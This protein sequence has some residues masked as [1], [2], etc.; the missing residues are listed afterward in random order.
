MCP[1]EWSRKSHLRRHLNLRHKLSGEKAEKELNKILGLEEDNEKDNVE[2]QIGNEAAAGE[3][4]EEDDLL[5]EPNFEKIEEQEK[6]INEAEESG[7]EDSSRN[8]GK[9]IPDEEIRDKADES[10]K[11][12]PN[13]NFGEQVPE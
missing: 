4:V 11:E 1:A 6:I 3:A 10:V 7:E 9:Q 12:D 2:L 8:L 13:R 5:E